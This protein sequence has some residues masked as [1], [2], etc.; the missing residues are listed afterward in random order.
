MDILGGVLAR[1]NG[2]P[3][4]FREPSSAKAYLAT[5]KHYVRV[6]VG[7]G[8]NAIVSNSAGGDDYW[9]NHLPYS[10]RYVIV[11]GLPFSEIESIEAALPP[12]IPDPQTPIVLYAGRLTSDASAMK[13]LKALLESLVYVKQQ[14][15]IHCILCGEG[16][17]RR[18]LE[19]VR[20]KLGLDAEVH[21]MGHLAIT[22]VWAL[23]KKASVFV[24]LSAYEGCP[25]TVMEAMACACPLILSDIPAH[26]ELA[27][28]SW[29]LFVDPSNTK[30]TA[31][32][33]VTSLN[34]LNAAKER[35]LA[36]KGK[37]HEWSIEKMARNYEKLY[38]NLI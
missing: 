16:P 4:I 9:R 37:V 3:W 6:R 8:A 17:Q 14:I 25:N 1:L 20:H 38:K 29:A 32:A 21:F 18:E 22:S 34:K 30:Q 5:W 11:N 24:S 28:E 33:I 12:G 15:K 31:N 19:M 7:S 36:A 27:N 2:V 10:R 23:M 35:A 26:R 13:N